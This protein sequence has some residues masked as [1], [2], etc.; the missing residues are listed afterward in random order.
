MPNP[1]SLQRRGEGWFRALEGEQVLAEVHLGIDQTLS[2]AARRIRLFAERILPHWKWWTGG[3]KRVCAKRSGRNGIAL[4]VS[5]GFTGV[6]R[7][8][9]GPGALR[10]F[11]VISN[12]NE[13]LPD[14]LSLSQ[15][16]GDSM[17]HRGAFPKGR[18]VRSGPE[19][20]PQLD[21]WHSWRIAY[22]FLAGGRLDDCG[23]GPA[24]GG[25]GDA[26]EWPR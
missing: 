15:V 19:V 11:P 14:L 10:T 22:S 25:T 24:A 23:Q 7:L 8:A 5:G 26:L 16:S 20:Q 1:P 6:T 12:E 9:I 2:R 3:L 13:C 21:R 17:A 4:R 18:R